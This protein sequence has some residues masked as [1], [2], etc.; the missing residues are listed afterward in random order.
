MGKTLREEMAW[1]PPLARG[2]EWSWGSSLSPGA[3]VPKVSDCSKR[4]GAWL[5]NH[6]PNRVLTTMHWLVVL[7]NRDVNVHS[8]EA[9]G[10]WSVS[11][12]PTF[13]V[14]HSANGGCQCATKG[15]PERWN[16]T[17][18]GGNYNSVR[19]AL[20]EYILGS[21]L[22]RI[23]DGVHQGWVYGRPE[24]KQ[25]KSKYTP[26]HQQGKKTPTPSIPIK[27]IKETFF[28]QLHRLSIHLMASL[29]TAKAGWQWSTITCH[30]IRESQQLLEV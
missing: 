13:C 18:W 19:Q 2:S 17:Q 20:N 14:C 26:Q 29:E 9:S 1:P 5:W 21:S 7:E 30:I 16:R 8:H 25:K 12:K 23:Y 4:G 3:G 27:L 22:F 10:K 28:P 11:I 6:L 24:R 15:R